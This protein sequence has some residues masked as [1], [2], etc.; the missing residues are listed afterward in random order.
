MYKVGLRD[1]P[2]P[3]V[4]GSGTLANEVEKPMR[5]HSGASITLVAWGKRV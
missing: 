3:N 2:I 4:F 1:V 5:K